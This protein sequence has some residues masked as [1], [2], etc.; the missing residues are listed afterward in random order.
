MHAARVR[1]TLDADAV[2]VRRLAIAIS[3]VIL[4]SCSDDD[5]RFGDPSAIQGKNLP[6]APSLDFFPTEWVANK[7]MPAGA[8]KRHAGAGQVMPSPDL[9]CMGCH[10]AP[11]SNGAARAL[12]AGYIGSRRSGGPAKGADVVV[13]DQQ[14]RRAEAKSDDDGFFWIGDDGNG[15]RPLFVAARDSANNQIRMSPSFTVGN[16]TSSSC[17]GPST[18]A[19]Y[20]LLP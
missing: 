14:G 12:F 4:S 10:G 1:G 13:I 3:C 17:H 11:G 5:P 6:G 15:D 19:G 18:T 2:D 20:A 16:C 8:V 7:P 9:S